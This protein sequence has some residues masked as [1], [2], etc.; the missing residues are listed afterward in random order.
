MSALHCVSARAPIE[1]SSISK[2]VL[3]IVH[4]RVEAH[5]TA[6]AEL[7]C[8]MLYGLLLHCTLSLRHMMQCGT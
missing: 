7:L 5:G 6:Y 1:Y 3:H 8:L 2:P 4:A